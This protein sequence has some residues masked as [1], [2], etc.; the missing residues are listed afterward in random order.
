MGRGGGEVGVKWGA[1]VVCWR[2]GGVRLLR[3]EL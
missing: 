1:V 2:L 3:R